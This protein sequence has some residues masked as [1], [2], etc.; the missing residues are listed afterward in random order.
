MA[1]TFTRQ[2]IGGSDSG[3]WDTYELEQDSIN[4]GLLSCR[5]Y[6][7][8]GALTISPGRIGLDPGA[9]KGIYRNTEAEAISIAGISNGNWFKVE[10]STVGSVPTVAA[11]DI[12]GSTDPNIVP[13]GFTGA[14]DGEKGGYY[15]TATKRVIAIGYKTAG[16]ALAGILNCKPGSDYFSGIITNGTDIYDYEYKN[17]ELISNIILTLTANKTLTGIKGKYILHCNAG[18]N[19]F[20]IT[21]PSAITYPYMEIEADKTD[22]YSTNKSAVTIKTSQSI[23]AFTAISGSYYVFLFKKNQSIKLESNGSTWII[24]HG[25]GIVDMSTGGENTSDWTDRHLGDFVIVYDTQTV[26]FSI[27]E[28]ITLASGVTGIIVWLDATTMII[29]HATGAGIAVNNES[30][31][32]SWGGSALVNGSTKNT[33][34][35]IYHGTGLYV[36][37]FVIIYGM[38][39]NTTFDQTTQRII[40]DFQ[41]DGVTSAKMRGFQLWGIDTNNFKLQT[42]ATSQQLID[43]TGNQIEVDSEDYSYY[44]SIQK[45]Y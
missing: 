45:N 28:K 38:T 41:P 33:D 12:A 36:S 17:S 11:A 25:G 26:A 24:P 39:D 37:D 42:A 43:D 30:I 1:Q 18:A 31:T 35:N 16:G 23:N 4:L 34:S 5:L 22:L 7:N 14:Y 44:I 27:G 21:V 20:V 9:T 2:A 40:G 13:A 6:S 3:V 8:A 29:K 19:G 10:L 32:G 15:I